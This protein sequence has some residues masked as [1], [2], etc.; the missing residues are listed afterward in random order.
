MIAFV[1]EK[2]KQ[3]V[4]GGDIWFHFKEGF[5]NAVRRTVK[6]QDLL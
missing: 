1:S 6:L 5:S 3:E 2:S 4:I